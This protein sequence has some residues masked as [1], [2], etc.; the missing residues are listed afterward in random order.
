MDRLS[1]LRF[2]TIVALSLMFAGAAFAQKAPEKKTLVVNG[3]TADGAVVQIDDHSYVDVETF[4]RIMNAAVSFEPG[5]VILTASV[6]F[7]NCVVSIRATSPRGG[8]KFR[9]GFDSASDSNVEPSRL[10]GS[11]LRT[12]SIQGNSTIL[13]R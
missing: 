9:L 10:S 4:A 11:G 1:C 3:R 7:H 2:L 5:R 13:I 6:V 8:L 12:W